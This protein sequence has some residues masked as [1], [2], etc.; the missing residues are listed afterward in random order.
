MVNWLLPVAMFPKTFTNFFFENMAQIA[1]P[2]F[3]IFVLVKLYL[4]PALVNE[5]VPERRTLQIWGAMVGIQFILFGWQVIRHNESIHTY[6]LLHGWMA[7]VQLLIIIWA[8]YAVQKVFIRDGIDVEMFIRSLVVTLAVY[9]VFVVVPQL[10]VTLHLPFTGWTNALAGLFERHW[11]DRSWYDDGSYVATINRVNG[12]EPEAPFLVML[13]GL[14]FSPVLIGIVHE[15]ILRRLRIGRQLQYMTWFLMVLLTFVFLS[16]RASSGYMMLALLGFFTVVSAPRKYRKIWL[17]IMA[18]G[19]VV[20]IAAY[21]VVPFVH[22]LLD[23]WI[24]NKSGTD[25][26]LGGT[27]GLAKTFLSHPFLGVGFGNEGYFIEQY[28]PEWSKHNSEYINVYSKMAYPV[29]NDMLGWLARY[30]A[31]VVL[32]GLWLLGGVVV[33]AVRAYQNILQDERPVASYYR[34]ALRAFTIMVP[35]TLIVSCITQIN[36]FSWPMLLMYFFYW[37]V[38]HLAEESKN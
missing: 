17:S 27:I 1:F 21:M 6:G 2:I 9:L 12:F 10:L 31:V 23:R 14:V 7:F 25:N 37:R 34:I 24:F 35:L 13:L 18:A 11:A 22:D 30:G 20:V 38:I 33:R 4:Q 26:R 19:V 16:V 29:L 5:L 15:P 28:L 36:A 8:A 3:L 32:S